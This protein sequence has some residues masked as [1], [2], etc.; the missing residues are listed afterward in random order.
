[1]NS[2][3]AIVRARPPAPRA[4]QPRRASP[5]PIVEARQEPSLAAFQAIVTSWRLDSATADALL[6]EP[7]QLTEAQL[8]RVRLL[9]EMDQ[10]APAPE[11]FTW[12]NAHPNMAGR[13]P[14]EHMTR[15]GLPGLR[16]VMRVLGCA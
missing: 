2:R 16:R 7:I 14:I 6:G 11:W 15:M 13:A 4:P 8:E 3:S 1:M 12:P 10:A 9:M 5:A